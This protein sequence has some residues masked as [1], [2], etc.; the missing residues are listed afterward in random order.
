MIEGGVKRAIII[1]TGALKYV[2]KVKDQEL[3]EF[4]DKRN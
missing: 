4:E 2:L 3:E 1:E